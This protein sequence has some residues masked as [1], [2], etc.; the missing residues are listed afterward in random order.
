MSLPAGPLVLAAVA[1]FGGVYIA[2]NF[3]ARQDGEEMLAVAQPQVSAPLEDEALPSGT[4]KIPGRGGQFALDACIGT[5]T[6][7]FL[8]DTGASV[9]A[10]TWESGYN[11]GLVSIG[12]KMDAKMSTANGTVM[13]KFVT[14]SR[15]ETGSL[16]VDNIQAVVMPKGA[17]AQNLL[18]MSFLGRLKSYSVASNVMTLTQ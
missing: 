16:R 9:V 17:L 8:V 11:L 15:I 10:L 14:I 3:A 12:D 13:G 18:G 4:V 1:C 2:Q 6:T 7:P 5:R